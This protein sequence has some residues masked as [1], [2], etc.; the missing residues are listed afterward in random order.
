MKQTDVLVTNAHPVLPAA[1]NRSD[2]SPISVNQNNP[3]SQC[4]LATHTFQAHN[5]PIY[6]T[7]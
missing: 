1:L 5:Y 6:F 4:P 7:S 3:T 2:K